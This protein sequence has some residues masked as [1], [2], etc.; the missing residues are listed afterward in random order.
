MDSIVSF[1][2]IA[3]QI[4]LALGLLFA[5]YFLLKGINQFD[6]DARG[7]SWGFRAIILPGVVLLWIVLLVKM[8]K[9]AR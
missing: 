3:F 7:S 9:S 5:I 8:R 2:W 1:V 4:Y 6:D